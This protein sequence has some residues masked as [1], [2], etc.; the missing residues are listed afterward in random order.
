MTNSTLIKQFKQRFG[1]KWFDHYSY[2]SIVLEREKGVY[3]YYDLE[4][5][6]RDIYYWIN[7][8]S[9]KKTGDEYN[10]ETGV[11]AKLLEEP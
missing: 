5:D 10:K 6:D 7:K 1:A 8:M 4:K 11:I 9:L 3:S 2:N